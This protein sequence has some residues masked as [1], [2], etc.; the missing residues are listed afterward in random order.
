MNIMERKS[1]Y[2]RK[3]NFIAERINNLPEHPE[4]NEFLIDA[5]FYRL[6]ITIDASMDIIAML[7]KD[8]GIKVEDDYSNIEHLKEVKI[9]PPLFLDNFRKW[10]G[11]RNVLVHKYNKIEEKLVLKEKKDLVK[12][13]N[14]FI[15]ITELFIN[16]N[17]DMLVENGKK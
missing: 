12:S 6:Q 14:S 3:I 15:K 2:K 17:S 4:E 8:L 7:C 11:L 13:L 16:K 5:L 9:F 10:N 1:Q